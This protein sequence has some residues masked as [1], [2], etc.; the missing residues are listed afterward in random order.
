[1]FPMRNIFVAIL[2]LGLGVFG[3][4]LLT[5]SS[6]IDA[7]LIDLPQEAGGIATDPGVL[8][9]TLVEEPDQIP[10]DQQALQPDIIDIPVEYAP[11]VFEPISAINSARFAQ[12][13]D[14]IYFKHGRHAGYVRHDFLKIDTESLTSLVTQQTSGTSPIYSDNSVNI[15]EIQL[16]M[17]IRI[18][19]DKTL[20]VNFD[21]ASVLDSGAYTIV[22]HTLD[23]PLN[24]MVSIT[25]DPA[26]GQVISGSVFDGTSN[27]VIAI[28]PEPPFYLIT[29]AI[30]RGTLIDDELIL[31]SNENE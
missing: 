26:I 10:R 2:I 29:E 27:H 18:A 12:W 15:T 9:P 16:P 3:Y 25:V 4:L 28:T 14:E 8:V 30:P 20:S 24:S 11:D 21:K 23:D 13:A 17:D 22:G 31:E 5:K 1:M 19:H 6:P 7:T